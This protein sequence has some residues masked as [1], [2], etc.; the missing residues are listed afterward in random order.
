MKSFFANKFSKQVFRL[1]ILGSVLGGVSCTN[2]YKDKNKDKSNGEE[3]VAKSRSE[4]P[5]QDQW[6]VE[7]IYANRG[8]WTSHFLQV[9][10]SDKAPYFNNLLVY[11][12]QL[13]DPAKA[14]EFFS[15]YIDLDRSLSKL[16]TYAH[17]RMDEDLGNDD[18]KHDFGKITS[19]M[20]AFALEFSW[21]EPEILA[22]NDEQFDA[23]LN[24]KELKEYSFYLHR[25]RRMKPHTLSP[26]LEQMMALSGKALDTSYKAFGA[27]NNADLTFENAKDSSGQEYP[28]SNGSYLTYLRSSDRTLR[29][30]AFKNLHAGYEKHA[31]TLCELLQG[32]VQSHLFYAKAKKFSSCLEAALFPH[33]IDTTVYTNLIQAV[34]KHLPS[35]H[36]YISF[37]KKKMG[38]DEIHVY[39]LYTPV[40]KESQIH[41]NY[42]DAC[43]AVVDSVAPLGKEYQTILSQ[44][45]F[46][47]RWVDAFEN[48]KKRSGAYSSG[49]YDTMPYILMNYHGNFGDVTTLA[50]EAGHSMHSFYSR[51]NQPYIYSHYSI[52][53]AEVASTFNEL[54]LLR[55]MKDKTQSKEE[56]A[57]LINDEIE[58]IRATIFRQ[59]MF[60]E[61]ELQI[62]QW[63]EEG[64]PLTPAL[65]KKKYME[66]NR[67]YY[68]SEL[69]LDQE[70]E[71]EWARIPHF[72]YNFYVYQYA[73]G[74]SAAMALNQKAL[75]SDEAKNR[76]LAFLGSGGSDYPI[77]LLA[78]AGVDMRSTDPIDQALQ[79]FSQLVEKLKELSQ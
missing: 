41:M 13:H 46:K 33:S 77:Q 19:L 18:S 1:L 34:R 66:L 26:E 21:V 68:G 62:H 32:Q 17:L 9:Q 64:I 51:K 43:Q 58:R 71:I 10:G 4:I 56:L 47:D 61:F 28:L 48:S 60:A 37:R 12:G 7:A 55:L 54:L 23:L 65:L 3:K 38:L 29:Q 63:A 49:C 5:K 75:Q 30:T 6:N 27:L 39:D 20:H 70:L 52:F 72:Y 16:Y 67:D 44:G 73:T 22:L 11:E 15:K 35:M 40:V 79:R 42:S 45:L 59:T 24:N 69:V 36:D 31:N 2:Q 76:Y 8:D 78:K 25:M 57:Y 74:L 53:V 14:K 50:H